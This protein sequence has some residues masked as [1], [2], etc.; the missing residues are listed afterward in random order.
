MKLCPTT[1]NGNV[2]A[3]CPSLSDCLAN[4]VGVE[5][6]V[7]VVTERK[8][9]GVKVTTKTFIELNGLSVRLGDLRQALLDHPD[10]TVIKFSV[11]S[12]GGI[13]DWV[14]MEIQP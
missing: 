10:D 14:T 4:V 1:R 13:A 7:R 9:L 3:Y 2:C 5:K 12:A 6:R 11:R 8:L